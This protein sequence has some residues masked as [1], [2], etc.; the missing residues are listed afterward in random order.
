[1]IDTSAPSIARVYDQGGS[2]VIIT[3]EP[4]TCYASQVMCDFDITNSTEMTGSDVLHTFAWN[5]ARAAY[6]KCT[7]NLGNEP[8]SCNMA[9]K[10][11]QIK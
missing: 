3:D 1:M 8:G 7:D 5:T 10:R 2:L 9:V 11:G 6:I 4:A